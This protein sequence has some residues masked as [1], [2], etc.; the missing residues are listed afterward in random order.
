MKNRLVYFDIGAVL[1]IQNYL[2]LFN[3][4]TKLSG[5]PYD[6]FK[7][8]YLASR[9]EPR[10]LKGE[11]TNEEF[12]TGVH[13]IMADLGA[14]ISLAESI[15]L[16]E[17]V[18]DRENTPVVELK[19]TIH[20]LGARVGILSNAND[21]GVNFNSKKFPKVFHVYEND[22]PIIYSHELKRVKPELA[23]YEEADKRARELGINNITFIDDNFEYV[24]FPAEKFGWN[25]IW[26]NEHVDP[27]EPM[28]KESQV[29][30]ASKEHNIKV[31]RNVFELKKALIELG[32]PLENFK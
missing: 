7:K 32:F 3:G 10:S 18:L 31:A 24:R 15:K 13:E 27:G 1:V 14:D 11:I 28:R 5:K 9:L 4:F 16:Q 2:G 22:S 6:E 29:Q 25:G 23:I 12:V 20:E 26:Y 30:D 19:K 8:R 21:F 17:S